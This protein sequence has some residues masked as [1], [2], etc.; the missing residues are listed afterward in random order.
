MPFWLRRRLPSNGPIKILK[1][2]TLWVQRLISDDT[3]ES[4]SRK[5][6]FSWNASANIA[7]SLSGGNFLV[8]LYTILK[9]GDVLLGLFTT[10]IQLCCIFQIFSPLLLDRFKRKKLVLLVTRIIF[11]SIYIVILGIIPYLPMEDGMR[12]GFLLVAIIFAYL[13][14]AL[15]APGYS[16]LH[17]RSIPEGSRADFFTVL[18]L[19][20]NIGIYVFILL[21]GFIV[22]FFRDHGNFLAGLNAVRI[23]AVIFGILEIYSHCHIHEFEEPKHEEKRRLLNPFLPLKNKQFTICAVMTGLYSFFANIPGLYYSSYLINDVVVP[24]SFLGMVHFLSVP[25]MIIFVPFWNG[26]IKKRSWFGTI[27]P[28]LILVSF[29]YFSLVFLNSSNYTLLYTISC[30][31]Y[32]SMV[33]GVSIV[34]S[35]LPFYRLPESDR[36]IY[37]AF[38]SSF[39]SFMAMLGIFC[40]SLFIAA[41][42]SMT[43]ELFGW[44]IH[45]KQYIMFIT[46]VLLMGLGLGYRFFSKKEQL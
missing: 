12:I 46:G 20:N 4:V 33:P 18:S 28:A 27:S 30:I 25:C 5:Y 22:D 14:N 42:G 44:S 34:I 24:Y 2:K 3:Q 15:A 40:G 26:V 16:V 8:G 17:I 1:G 6:I 31:Y 11:Y 45:N 37:M 35:N 10:I 13:I 21:C 41:T 23:I 36:T 9:V 38:W 43:F 7:Q 29:H 39:N 32:Y 19:L